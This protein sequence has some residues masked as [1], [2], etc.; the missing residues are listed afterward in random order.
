MN[1]TVKGI[2]FVAF[3]FFTIFSSLVYQQAVI[4]EEFMQLPLNCEAQLEEDCNRISQQRKYLLNKWDGDLSHDYLVVLI[5][6]MVYA[7]STMYLVSKQKS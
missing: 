4:A 1:K 5:S 6:F 2:G 3:I 7:G